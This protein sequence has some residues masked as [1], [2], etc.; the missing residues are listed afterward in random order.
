MTEGK[1]RNEFD[2]LVLLTFK[3]L[4]LTGLSSVLGSRVTLSE[5]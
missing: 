2:M 4:K 5:S 1:C 3:L